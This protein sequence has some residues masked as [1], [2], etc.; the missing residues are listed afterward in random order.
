RLAICPMPTLTD[1]ELRAFI[2]SLPKTELHLHME[3]GLP[4]ELLEEVRPGCGAPASWADGFKFR[5][6]A[7]FE[8]ELLDMAFAFYTSPEN[9]HR[10][11]K[12]Q[13]ERY[14][15]MNVRYVE[16]SFAS[17]LIEFGGLNVR[18]VFEAIRDAAPD[19]LEIRVFMGIHHNGCGAKMRPV[20]E[21]SLTWSGFAGLDLHGVEET[22][23]EPWTA[24]IY[25]AARKAGK[26]TKAHAGEFMGAD[27]V[28]RMIEEIG[29]ERIEHG[30]RSVEAPEVVAL[31]RERGIAL[32]MCP[33][34]NAKLMPGITL[35]NHPIRE[36]YD[37]GVKIT[38]NTDDPISFGNNLIDDYEAIA[39]H[40][41][42]TRA[43]LKQ[44]ARNGLEVALVGE[45]TRKAWLDELDA[46]AV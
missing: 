44:L 20:I 43:E 5:D 26:F 2:Q 9:Y 46:I 35:D 34:S 42:F 28:R 38:V 1:S 24:E 22:P 17:G 23:I 14:L 7:H 40:R 36:L 39:R 12:M 25:E 8:G 29:A 45:S 11:A 30:V 4:L 15:A 6:F 16:T 3:G 41:G 10:S 21:D 19:G 27:F 32:D 18:E 33:I 13:F 31:L 37:A